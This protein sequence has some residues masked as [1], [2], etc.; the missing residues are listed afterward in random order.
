MK[1]RFLQIIAMILLLVM[2]L[3]ACGPAATPDD[4]N[5]DANK[6]DAPATDAPGSGDIIIEKPDKEIK[7]IVNKY[8]D[9]KEAVKALI[10]AANG[11]GGVDNITVVAL[12][13]KKE[14]NI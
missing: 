4:S 8:E 3:T 13:F 6:T 7:N 11:N 9:L 5:D 10:D 14:E 1:T 12:Q 2:V